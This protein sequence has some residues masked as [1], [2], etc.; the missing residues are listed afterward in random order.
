[1]GFSVVSPASSQDIKN[2]SLEAEL[3]L[4]SAL[5]GAFDTKN[6][7]MGYEYEVVC[8]DEN[9]SPDPSAASVI[10]TLPVKDYSR[11]SLTTEFGSHNVEINGTPLH[12]RDKDCFMQM[13]TDQNDALN[14]LESNSLRPCGCGL[15][16]SSKLEDLGEGSAE[17][18]EKRMRQLINPFKPRYDSLLECW[19]RENSGSKKDSLN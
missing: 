6:R 15:L 3:F 19:H 16:L 18:N 11:F 2:L 17:F 13:L 1:M 4:E 9:G 10:N 8:I 5:S 12:L 14:F 7:S